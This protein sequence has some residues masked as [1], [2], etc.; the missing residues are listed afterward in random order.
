ME[1]S[2]DYYVSLIRQT[3][4]DRYPG[5]TQMYKPQHLSSQNYRV[6]TEVIAAW[7]QSHSRHERTNTH[8]LSLHSW[9]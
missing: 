9:K 3:Q 7:G 2:G 5:F 6:E 8:A 4:K 1:G